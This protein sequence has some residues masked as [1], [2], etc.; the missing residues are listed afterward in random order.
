MEKAY[1]Y[2]VYPTTEQEQILRRTIGCVRLV[3]N[4]ALAA[5]T[6]AWYEK[7]QRVDYVQTSAMLTQWKKVDDLQFLNEVSCVPL[8][9][10]LR[11]LQTAFANFF[12]GRAKYPNFKKKR[13]GGS[14]EFTKS[15]FR[16]KDGQLYLAKCSEPLPI[17]WSRQLP[18]GCEPSTITVK[19]D[20][21]GRWFVSLRINDPKDETMRE[22]D[23]AVGLDVGISSLVTLST[24]EKIANPKA[25]GAHYRKLRRAQK[26]LSRKQKGSRNRERARLKVARIHAKISDTRTDHLHKLTTQL[27]RENQTIV[28]EDLA[29]KNMVKNPKLARAISDAAW[30]ELVRQL[31]YK[32]KWY[33]RNLVKIDRW[34]PSSKRCGNCGHVVDK[35]PLNVREWDCP[36]CGAHHDRD[37]NAAEN[38]LA[39]GHPVTVCGANI[40]PDRHESKGGAVSAVVR[41]TLKAP[42]QLRKTRKG[43]KQKPKS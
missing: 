19:L 10:G 12:A 7:Q 22:R 2:R 43:K 32:A 9:Q 13:S 18:K 41:Q 8:Q 15:A 34:F 28:V 1:R 20:P 23:S 3:F 17:K 29:V 4:K 39:V 27:I 11:H 35:L 42:W 16:W 5:R 14:A 40:R 6:E 30:G 25:F 33:G 26:S 38:I 36:N 31:E 24:G 21:S 37:L